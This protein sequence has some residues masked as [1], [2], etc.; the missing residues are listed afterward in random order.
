MLMKNY[1]SLLN[2]QIYYK[3]L[4]QIEENKVLSYPFFDLKLCKFIHIF[5]IV[6]E[7]VN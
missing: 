4:I 1:S 3:F 2:V 7:N 5:L 6:S